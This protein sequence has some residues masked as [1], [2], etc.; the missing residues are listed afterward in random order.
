MSQATDLGYIVMAVPTDM[1]DTVRLLDSACPHLQRSTPHRFVPESALSPK[2]ESAV[3]QFTIPPLLVG[4]LNTLMTL[5]D[6]LVKMDAAARAA[7]ANIERQGKELH[8]QR[9]QA[10]RGSGQAQGDWMLIE[11]EKS[12]DEYLLNFTWAEHKFPS[13]RPLLDLAAMIASSVERMEDELRH[14]QQNYAEKR[15][16]KLNLERRT[17]GNLLNA[18]IDTLLAVR[19][20]AGEHGVDIPIEGTIAEERGTPLTPHDFVDTQFLQTVTLT[21]PINAVENFE[22]EVSVLG[23]EQVSGEEGAAGVASAEGFSPVVPH[24]SLR[25]MSDK[26]SAIFLVTVLKTQRRVSAGGDVE[27]WEIADSFKAACRSKRFVLREFKW[28]PAKMKAKRLADAQL[29]SDF[30]D[31]EGKTLQWCSVHYGEAVIAWAH[32]K[33]IRVF[34]ESV[35]RYGLPPQFSAFIMKPM[36]S[37]RRNIR[38]IL[39]ELYGHLDREGSFANDGGGGSG[40]GAGGLLSSAAGEFYPYVSIDF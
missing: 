12:R 35:L 13:Q 21:V 9:F 8:A 30:N 26:D 27:G 39:L 18:D 7:V 33:A 29:L 17:R 15:N 11:G 36:K 34:V 22:K 31:Y 23:I 16:A 2:V 19:T 3:A 14:F 10:D 37:K 5:S 32:L 4:T 20:R 25:V 38:K 40:G 1:C 6:D 24:S 28:D